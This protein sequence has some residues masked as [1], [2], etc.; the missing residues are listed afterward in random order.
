[1]AALSVSVVVIGSV[2]FG[3][4]VR[5]DTGLRDIFTAVFMTCVRFGMPEV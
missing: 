2:V 1:M 4:V 5:V 3:V